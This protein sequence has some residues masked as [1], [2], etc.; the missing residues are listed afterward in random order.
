MGTLS[1]PRQ[2]LTLMLVISFSAEA[3][4]FVHYTECLKE[5]EY[6]GHEERDVNEPAHE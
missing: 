5:D 6:S 3:M 2:V 4:A 1:G